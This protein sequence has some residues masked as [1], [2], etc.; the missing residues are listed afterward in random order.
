MS[1][2]TLSITREAIGLMFPAASAHLA[3]T[4]PFATGYTGMLYGSQLPEPSRYS[5]VAA[6]A[7][8]VIATVTLVIV[9]TS[10]EI[11]IAGADGGVLS[12]LLT[13]FEPA[14]LILP[15]ASEHLA[16]TVL[17]LLNTIGAE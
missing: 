3:N 17:L 8:Y 16:K 11:C 10:G 12:I 7:G 5:F 1:A 13:V 2:T 14:L 15:A 4:V 9:G 6:S